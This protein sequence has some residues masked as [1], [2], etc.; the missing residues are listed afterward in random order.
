MTI[1]FHC[2]SC[3]KKLKANDDQVGQ[4]F[5]CSSCGEIAQVPSVDD[6]DATTGKVSAFVTDQAGPDAPIHFKRR[7]ELETE[8]DMTPM[9]D[10]TFLLLIFFMVTAAFAMQK[11]FESPTRDPIEDAAAP[12]PVNEQ[13]EDPDNIVVE[14]H[15]NNDIWVDDHETPTRQSLLASLKQVRAERRPPPRTL[16][17]QVDPKSAYWAKILVHD[18]GQLVGMENIREI[19]SDNY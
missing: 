19:V 14:I 5:R 18:V 16:I 1:R 2:S 17:I 4:R 13:L 12:Q 15:A 11:A 6:A 9:V 3:R 10:V 8:M 7:V